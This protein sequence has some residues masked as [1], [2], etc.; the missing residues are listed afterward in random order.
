MLSKTRFFVLHS[1]CRQYGSIFNIGPR[2]D[3]F[4]RK[5]T[6]ILRR[7]RSFKVTDFGTNA[8]PI[9]VFLL[10]INTNLHRISRRF[11]IIADYLSNLRFPV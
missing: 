5:L 10:T 6:T 1:C 3:E 7:S 11:Q 4:G 8:K 9:W 2:A